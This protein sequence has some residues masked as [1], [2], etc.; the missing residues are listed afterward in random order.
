[1]TTWFTSDLHFGHARVIE[2]SNR[3]FRNVDE[4]D[5]ALID[6][7]NAFVQ[8]GDQV[9][10]VGDFSFHKPERTLS[11]LSSLQGQ[12]GLVLGNHDKRTA[13]GISAGKSTRTGSASPD[14]PR[15]GGRSSL[16][17]PRRSSG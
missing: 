4:M 13:S 5:A 8:S 1:M 3:P 14:T 15:V 11:I 17:S 10:V 6:N 7:W 12:I 2:Y 9:H 16:S